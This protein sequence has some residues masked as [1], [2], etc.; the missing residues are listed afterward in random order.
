MVKAEDEI[1]TA[2]VEMDLGASKEASRTGNCFYCILEQYSWC[3][4]MNVPTVLWCKS[5][6]S[7]ASTSVNLT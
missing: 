6:L 5:L 3:S 2:T 7:F 4:L 1:E